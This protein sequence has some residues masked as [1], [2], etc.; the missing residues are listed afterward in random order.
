VEIPDIKAEGN[1]IHS[2]EELLDDLANMEVER[3]MVP[4]HCRPE[5]EPDDA[6]AK[7]PRYPKQSLQMQADVLN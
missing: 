6:L 4:R 2:S 1:P 5:P 7:C 3:V